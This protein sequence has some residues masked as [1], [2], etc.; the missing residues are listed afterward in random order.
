[1]GFAKARQTE[2]IEHLCYHQ[3]LCIF[4]ADSFNAVPSQIP[5]PLA[6]ILNE[7]PN[8]NKVP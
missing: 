5:K 1:M 4:S 6:A 3:L 8:R 2:V 7:L